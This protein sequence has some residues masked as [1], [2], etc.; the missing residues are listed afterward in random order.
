MPVCVISQSVFYFKYYIFCQKVSLCGISD[1]GFISNMILLLL[2]LLYQLLLGVVVEYEWWSLSGNSGSPWY[3]DPTMVD[4]FVT[5][6]VIDL[7]WHFSSYPI[8]HLS[9][10]C[11]EVRTVEFSVWT[12]PVGCWVVSSWGRWN[13]GTWASSI[14]D[15]CE[16]VSCSSSFSWEM[17]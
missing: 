14:G 17:Q 10:T 12:S 11:S 16:T 6:P 13:S 15:W 9:S 1:V 3:V 8:A 5:I 7:P 2:L 4:Y